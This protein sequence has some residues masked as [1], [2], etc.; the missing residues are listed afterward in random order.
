MIQ[1]Q[2]FCS[3]NEIYL[4]VFS[5]ETAASH[6]IELTKNLLIVIRDIDQLSNI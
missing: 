2:S 1:F 4:V 3:F 5:T 6:T